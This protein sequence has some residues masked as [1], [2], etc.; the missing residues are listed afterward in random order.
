MFYIKKLTKTLTLP[1][2]NYTDSLPITLQKSLFNS[3]EGKCYPNIG[4]IITVT[5]ILSIS[6]N[7]LTSE[8]YSSF[9]ITYTALTLNLL[10]GM[11]IETVVKEV[12]NMGVFANVGA[13]SIFISKMQM[14]ESYKNKIKDDIDIDNLELDS[15]IC[16][17]FNIR[18]RIIGTKIENG[19]M[20]VIGSIRDECLGVI[21]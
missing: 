2:S 9:T 6:Q 4:I 18:V 10:Q 3:V 15:I 7:I 5:K 1:P 19:R 13:A 21:N 16:K 11:V 20:F 12:N 17:G 14:P 8:G